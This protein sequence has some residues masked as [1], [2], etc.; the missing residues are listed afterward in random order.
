MARFADDLKVAI[1]VASVISK[2]D[3][4]VY[5]CAYLDTTVA[6]A[7]LT[8]AAIALEY[9]ISDGHPSAASDA[10]GHMFS[11]QPLRIYRPL[12]GALW[13]ALLNHQPFGE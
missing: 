4:V 1:V 5:L 12:G 8:Q 11:S 2:R 10:L 3:D 7:C 9:P 6:L 13:S